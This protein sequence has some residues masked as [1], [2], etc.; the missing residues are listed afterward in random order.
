MDK[1]QALEQYFGYTSFRPGQETI[2]DALLSGQ[3][4]LA[5]MPTGAGKSLCFQ[6]PALL[7]GGLTL[8]ISPLISLMKDQVEALGQNGI[9]AVCLHSQMEEKER[10]AAWELLRRGR[11]RL[12]YIA[13]E[14]LESASFCSWIQRHPPKLVCVDEAHCVSQWGQDFRPG[15]L[16]IR[17][18]L[19]TLPACPVGAF[20]ATATA[21]VRQDV[22][23]LLGLRQPVTVSTGFDRPNLYFEVRRPAHKWEELRKLLEPRR[24]VTGIVYCSTRSQVDDVAGR[25]KQAGF[26]AAAYHAGMEAQYRRQ[27]QEKF[28]RDEVRVMVA[29]NAFGMG[30]DKSNIRYVIHYNMPG[31]LESY[32]QEAG[33]A[34]RDGGEADCILLFGQSDV[35]TQRILLSKDRENE[36]LPP[37]EA[38]QV[39]QRSLYRLNKMRNYCLTDRCLRRV[40]LEYFGEQAPEKCDHCSS[41]LSGAVPVEMTSQA[42]MFLCCALRTGQRFGSSLLISVLRGSKSQQVLERGLETQSTYG[43]WRQLEPSLAQRLVQKLE[44]MGYIRLTQGEYPVVKVTQKAKPL[45]AGKEKL[46]LALPKQETQPLPV[47]KDGLDEVSRRLFEQLRLRRRELAGAAGVAPY[48]VFS[49]A[50][51]QQ[52]ARQRP[53]SREQMSKISGVGAVKLERYGDAF[54]EVIRTFQQQRYRKGNQAESKGVR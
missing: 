44:E 26:S 7:L 16:K 40:L 17:P 12:L 2:V 5:V 27:A 37:E 21:Q 4:V 1:L 8:V 30:I 43:M 42:Q 39:K 22:V 52:M 23:Q 13:P 33:R 15:Y 41:C 36:T 51:L 54:L 3:D 46:F 29:T 47:R 19:D 10:T 35:M 28:S 38:E 45:L 9:S 31:D 24:D 18:F 11:C 48:V 20:T 14:R 53:V 34:G 50:T 32:Y 25:L 49:D 6:L